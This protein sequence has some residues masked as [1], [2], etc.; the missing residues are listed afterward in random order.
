[1]HSDLVLKQV[2]YRCSNEG[3]VSFFACTCLAGILS[4]EADPNIV[5]DVSG[6]SPL[7][8]GVASGCVPVSIA[9]L[10]SGASE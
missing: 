4:Y 10:R 3:F 6:M 2:V 7:M 9:L 8:Y 1:M 5:D